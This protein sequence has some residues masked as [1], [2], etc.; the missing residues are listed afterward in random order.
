MKAT[1]K[2][3]AQAWY[4]SLK[5]ASPED[6]D[7]ISE[8]FLDHLRDSGNMKMLSDVLM[9]MEA[10]ET[11]EQ[12]LETVTIRSA[13]ELEQPVIEDILSKVLGKTTAAVNKVVDESLLGGVQV[14]TENTRWDLSL[15]GQLRKLQNQ[16]THNA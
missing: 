10:I 14:E 11:A 1:A 3:Y 16:L 5:D 8:R 9:H 6:M 4:S 13:H 15:R 7:A 12:G 2:Q